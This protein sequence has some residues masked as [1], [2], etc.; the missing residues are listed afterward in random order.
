MALVCVVWVRSLPRPP[1]V[2]GPG[3]RVKVC[4]VLRFGLLP[5]HLLLWK[6][7][8]CFLVSVK[9]TSMMAAVPVVSSPVFSKRVTLRTHLSPIHL[10]QPIDGVRELLN[11]SQMRYVESLGGVLLSYSRL[12]L[13]EPLGLIS[14]DAPEVH[15]RVQ[16][17]AKYFSPKVGDYIE[18]TVSR[19]GGDHIGLLV[20]SIFNGSVPHPSGARR[21]QIKQGDQHVFIVRSVTHASGLISMHGELAEPG[22]YRRADSRGSGAK[23]LHAAKTRPAAV[24]AVGTPD[25]RA[26]DAA[27]EVAEMLSSSA[28]PDTLAGTGTAMRQRSKEECE[29]RKRHKMRKFTKLA[30][31]ASVVE[32]MA[33]TVPSLVASPSA[34]AT[35]GGSAEGAGAQLQTKKEHVHTKEEREAKKRR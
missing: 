29:E 34:A 13:M 3:V 24:G 17:L 5:S 9:A 18:G 25:T 32:A 6:A 2:F 26:P 28:V 15:V 27:A 33:S 31:G 21:H 19:I 20:H 22:S 1:P 8:V 12:R 4:V 16:F 30:G 23:C 7:D 10:A 11:R 14:G 35:G